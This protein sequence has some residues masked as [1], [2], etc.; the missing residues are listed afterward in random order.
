MEIGAATEAAR[1]RNIANGTRREPDIPVRPG[2]WDAVAD[3][4]ERERGEK[5]RQSTAR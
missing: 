1:Q 4:L 2:N 5:K 3:A